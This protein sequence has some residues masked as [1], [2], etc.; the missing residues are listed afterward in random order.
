MNAIPDGG[1]MNPTKNV[2]RA[3]FRAA[4]EPIYKPAV[5]WLIVAVIVEVFTFVI[6]CFGL[7]ASTLPIWI[8]I[9]AFV[10]VIPLLVLSF[11]ACVILLVLSWRMGRLGLF[12]ARATIGML[13]VQPTFS[14]FR[15]F[16]DFIFRTTC[17]KGGCS[18]SDFVERDAARD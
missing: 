18:R 3:G 5:V 1:H 8:P 10:L 11:V 13:L 16:W 9:Q 15:L 4:P 6:A 7:F 12:L 17:K 2:T 14:Y